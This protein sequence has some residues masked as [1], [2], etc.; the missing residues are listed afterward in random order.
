MVQLPWRQQPLTEQ[1]ANDLFM[2]TL[3]DDTNDAP[4]RMVMGDLH[5][6]AASSL[7]HSLR[8]YARAKG[9]AWYVASIVPIQATWPS[10]GTRLQFAPDLFVAFA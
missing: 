9:L 10:T 7:A 5:F 1:E 3:E 8:S 4:R 6:W 2:V